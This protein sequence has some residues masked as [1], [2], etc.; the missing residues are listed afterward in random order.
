SRQKARAEYSLSV[1]W[2]ALSRFNYHSGAAHSAEPRNDGNQRIAVEFRAPSAVARNHSAF[3]PDDFTTAA[4]FSVSS[5]MSLLKSAGEP[6]SI[7]PPRSVRRR[8]TVG[9]A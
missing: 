7:K 1:M 5:I 9:S 3:A 8:F 2:S 6:G 4:H